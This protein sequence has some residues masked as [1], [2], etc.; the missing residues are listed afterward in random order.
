MTGGGGAAR[1]RRERVL[2]DR[3]V[4]IHGLREATLMQRE[5]VLLDDDHRGGREGD[6]Q[7][8]DD[9]F[10]P[11]AVREPLLDQEDAARQIRDRRHDEQQQQA[12][13]QQRQGE[14]RLADV[15]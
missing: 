9:V 5:P 11:V 10:Q 14:R 12:A 1:Q 15:R 7:L 13:Q 3:I 2:V 8:P 6:G 4:R